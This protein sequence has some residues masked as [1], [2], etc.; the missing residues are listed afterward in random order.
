LPPPRSRGALSA[1]RRRNVCI[2]QSEFCVR[3]P[4][5]KSP[6]AT[7]LIRRRSNP[8]EFDAESTTR[9]DPELSTL[10]KNDGAIA[11][12]VPRPSHVPPKQL[13][14]FAVAAARMYRCSARV[15]R[16]ALESQAL[17]VLHGAG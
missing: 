8:Q 3:R 9:I 16:V 5:S 12:Q 4:S 10:S 15:Q 17:P 1:Q 11:Q 6:H 13:V 7:L 14:P 2:A